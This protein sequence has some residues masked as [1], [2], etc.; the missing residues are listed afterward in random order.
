VTPDR[1]K[2]GDS[3]LDD[4]FGTI[5]DEMRGLRDL[6]KAMAK[7]EIQMENLHEDVS[8]CAESIKQHRD[9]FAAYLK[10][11][12]RLQEARRIER[13]TDMRWSIGAILTSAGLVIAALSV[14]LGHIG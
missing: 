5:A 8:T 2:W 6:P 13:R 9:D 3:R 12:E 14:I 7:F 4:K 10:E 11:Q 1:L